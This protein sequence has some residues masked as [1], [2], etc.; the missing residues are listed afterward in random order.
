M[1]LPHRAGTGAP[2]HFLGSPT[3]WLDFGGA[4]AGRF[5]APSP[6]SAP[7]VFSKMFWGRR[8][9][10]SYIA[11]RKRKKPC[12]ISPIPR[13][14]PTGFYQEGASVLRFV[15]AE[16]RILGR[17]VLVKVLVSSCSYTHATKRVVL[18]GLVIWMASDRAWTWVCTCTERWWKSAGESEN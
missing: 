7:A 14:S 17:S 15:R 3:R 10:Y 6:I 9:K 2:A 5:S 16:T 18:V 1:Y 11:C 12:Q 13:S 4:G 8:W